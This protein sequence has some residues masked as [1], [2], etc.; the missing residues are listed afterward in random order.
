MLVRR[1]RRRPNNKT[2]LGQCLLLAGMVTRPPSK[3]GKPA[4]FTQCCSST[5]DSEPTFSKQWGYHPVN[6]GQ[7]RVAFY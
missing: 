2:T 3:R 4:A 6:A 5:P 1:L 7:Y